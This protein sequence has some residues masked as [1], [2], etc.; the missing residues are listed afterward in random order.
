MYKRQVL[1]DLARLA[2]VDSRDT[3]RALATAGAQTREAMTLAADAGIDRLRGQ[4]RPR[5][6]LVAS[7]GGLSLIHI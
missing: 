4:E 6:V 1:D 7:L 3:L 5:S 2:H